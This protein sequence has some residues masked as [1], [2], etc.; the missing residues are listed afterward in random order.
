MR[1]HNY[2]S[3]VCWSLQFF[4]SRKPVPRRKSSYELRLRHMHVNIQSTSI[5][6]I[7]EKYCN[8]YSGLPELVKGQ[9]YLGLFFLL[10]FILILTTIADS[11]WYPF[12]GILQTVL[13]T[14]TVVNFVESLRLDEHVFT[15]QQA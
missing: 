8:N 2:P 10:V 1:S 11:Q 7:Y 4:S 3:S 13:D 15:F 5:V 6:D 14:M 9:I 12:A